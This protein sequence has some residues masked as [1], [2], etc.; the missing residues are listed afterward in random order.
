MT[1]QHIKQLVAQYPNDYQLGMVIRREI[2]KLEESNQI[3]KDPNQI[4]LEDMIN[5]VQISKHN[6]STRL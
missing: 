4:D 2:K 1:I 6:G 3:I 5:E